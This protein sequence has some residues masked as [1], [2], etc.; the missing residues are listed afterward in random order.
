MTAAAFD[1][2]LP[3]VEKPAT[4]RTICPVDASALTA[5]M[6]QVS[7]QAWM[8]EDE[9]KENKFSVFHS[10]RHIVFRF[11]EG[12]N[13]PR[14]AYETQAWVVWR[15]LVQPIMDQVAAACGLTRPEFPK[16]MFA[17]LLAGR[18]IDRHIDGRGSNP[19]V[20]KI[21][22][23]LVTNSGAIFSVGDENFHMPVGQAYEVNNIVPH[24]ARNDGAEDR[25]HLIFEMFERPRQS[26]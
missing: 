23:P 25:V 1:T 19:K 12:N 26:G 13:D 5:R 20:H 24:G 17:R 15:P 9:R 18:V 21:H 11:I 3:D 10:T 14:A 6:R 8:S 4:V 22:V 7:D 2:E 16:A